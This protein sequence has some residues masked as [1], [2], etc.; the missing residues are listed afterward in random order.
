MRMILTLLLLLVAL[1]PQAAR[2]TTIA[3]TDMEGLHQSADAV[4]LADVLD[5]SCEWHEGHI[6]TRNRLQPL[7]WMKG[8]P[9]DP[10]AVFELVSA[11]GRI[12]DL[13]THVPGADRYAP[14]QRVLIFMQARPDGTWQSV[15]MGFSAFRVRLSGT[16]FVAE[17][18]MDGAS[19]L[20][21]IEPEV[22]APAPEGT[23]P[24]VLPLLELLPDTP[25]GGAP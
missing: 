16:S 10:G 8:A 15:A 25:T 2:A 24:S 5:W 14:G 17:R 4:V 7:Q 9:A 19:V 6:R 18:M 22:W 20:V 12:D 1:P 11:G 21:E 23:F 13:A 3:G